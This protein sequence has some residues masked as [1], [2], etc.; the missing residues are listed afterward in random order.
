MNMK[1]INR[2]L[3]L[4]FLLGSCEAND[5]LNHTLKT[6]SGTYVRQAASDYSKAMD[7]LIVTP[8]DP[9]AGTY[10]ILRK[11]GFNRI[12]DGKL[13][14]KENKQYRM[15]TVWDEET[16]QLQEMKEGKIYTFPTDGS[17]L[18]AGTARYNKIK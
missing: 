13:Q 5:Q 3:F 16:H 6:I 11:T 12:A 10:I 2:V 17:E 1:K 9:K 4:V 18:L 15:V 8:Y 7:T 14:P